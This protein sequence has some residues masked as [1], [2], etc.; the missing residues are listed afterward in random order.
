VYQEPR[1]LLEERLSMDQNLRRTK[2]I[3]IRTASV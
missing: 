3:S 2:N 1:I